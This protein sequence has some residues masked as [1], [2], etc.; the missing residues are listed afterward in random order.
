VSE[1]S[2]RELWL[3][4]EP[5]HAVTYF[6][7]E[8]REAHAALGLRGFWMGYFAARAAPLGPVG[9]GVVE[10]TF[11]GF[12]PRM[13][14]RAIPDAWSFAAPDTILDARRRGA[15]RA[16]RRLAPSIDDDAAPPA[17][18]LRRIVD[19]A[20]DSARTL[21]AANRDLDPPDDPV[22]GL[23][24]LATC[25]REHRG[26]G[27]VAALSAEGLDGCQAH[28]LFAADTM[29]PDQLLR[30]SRGWTDDDWRRATARLTERGLLAGHGITDRGRTLRRAV[31]RRTDEL[32]GA[33]VSAIGDGLA[34]LTRRLEPM[35]RAVVTSGD[36]PFPNPMGLPR[37]GS[38]PR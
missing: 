7:P 22:E 30:D 13:V 38:T 12:A 1:H 34:D 9:P 37:L 11:F 2:A 36:L 14:R 16:L 18:A 23:W 19:Q 24:W 8:C 3:R 10:A 15:A 26:D 20:D 32:A 31:E 6:T 25:L 21:F 35:A 27:H 5:I 17:A 4:V 28:V 33:A 29:V